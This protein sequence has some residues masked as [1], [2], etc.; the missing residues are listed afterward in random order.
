MSMSQNPFQMRI[1][2]VLMDTYKHISYFKFNVNNKVSKVFQW[3]KCIYL[4][5]FI[6]V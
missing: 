5:L 4:S 2:A 1:W 6:N 3:D